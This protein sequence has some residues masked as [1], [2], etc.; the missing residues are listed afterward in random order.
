MTL[1]R[2]SS[3]CYADDTLA[4]SLPPSQR[5]TATMSNSFSLDVSMCL[6]VDTRYCGHAAPRR[7]RLAVH[8]HTCGTSTLHGPRGL[9][10]ASCCAPS[11]RP[12]R[13]AART[14]ARCAPRAKRFSRRDAYDASQRRATGVSATRS[15][16]C[17][18]LSLALPQWARL[19]LPSL[20]ATL[21]LTLALTLTQWI[22]LLLASLS[23]P[24]VRLLQHWVCEGS[25]VRPAG[26]MPLHTP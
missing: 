9:A 6:A 16:R 26:E 4:F 3:F 15:H 18:S 11:T 1:D 5:V 23:S 17:L 22:R 21:T 7:Q 8:R 2:P 24:Y 19:P 25:L 10:R 13:V 20:T 12:H 14:A